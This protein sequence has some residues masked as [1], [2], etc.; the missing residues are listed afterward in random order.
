MLQNMFAERLISA[1]DASLF[2]ATLLP[3]QRA[4]G[5]DGSTVL[6]RAVQEHNVLAAARVYTNVSFASLGVILGVP[7]AK[8][9]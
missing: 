3:H 7:Q 8:V 9:R 5:A 2:E 4:T 6:A 1:N